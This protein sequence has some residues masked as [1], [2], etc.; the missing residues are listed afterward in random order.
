MKIRFKLFLLFLIVTAIP[1]FFISVIFYYNAEE[2]LEDSILKNLNFVADAKTH[3]IEMTFDDLKTGLENAQN[4]SNVKK[5]LP[6]IAKFFDDKSGRDYIKT[7]EQLDGQLTVLQKAKEFE[8][9]LLVNVSGKIVYDFNPEH[10]KVYLGSFIDDISP[11][12]FE[13]SKDKIYFSDP[14]GHKKEV[15]EHFKDEL[16]L[17]AA[18]P[19]HDFEGKFIGEVVF[20][21]DLKSIFDQFNQNV[22]KTEETVIGKKIN[23]NEIL[24]IN[25]LLFDK[26][27]ALN[28][29][30]SIGDKFAIPI[31]NA[32]NGKNGSGIVIDYRGVEVLADWRYFSRLDWGI[33]SKIDVK[34]AFAPIN[35]L[36]YII[37]LVA[38]VGFFAV[39]LIVFAISKSISDPIEQ[40]RKGAEIIS[41]GNLNYKIG[42]SSKD[43]IGIFSQTFDKM[44]FQL[45]EL[46][47]NLEQ[48]IKGKTN[49]LQKLNR[50]LMTISEANQVAIKA[51]DEKKL[52]KDVCD[53]LIK[54]GGYR[55]AWVGYKEENENKDVRV[56]ASAGYDNGYL[57]KLKA[58]W[59]DTERGNGPTGIA[60]REGKIVA[61]PDLE[62]EVSFRPW[63]KD[64]L[65]R[66]YKG[67]IAIPLFVNDKV[68]GAISIY[69][70]FV[71]VFTSDE[72]KVLQELA[73]DLSYSIES[74]RNRAEKERVESIL[75]E[76]EERF[77]KIF[78][79]GQYGIILTGADSKFIKV[80]PAFS[81][82]TGYTEAELLAKKFSDIT[83][84]ETVKA[85]TESVPK[86]IRGEIPFY[87]TE[88]RYIK[89]NGEEVWVNLNISVIRNTD[90]SFG[91][92]LGM[93]EDISE[94]KKTEE[95]LRQR[96]EDL[97]KF[98]L[99]VENS[100]DHIII[101][102]LDGN[103]VYANRATEKITGYSVN[104]MLGKKPSLWG[105]QMDQ[106]FYKKMWHT[107]KDEKKTFVGEVNNKRK[108][109]Q[110]YFADVYI[111]PILDEN[112]NIKF[113][114]G[115]ERDITEEKKINQTKN[116]FI[117]IASHQLRTPMTGIRWVVERFLKTEKLTRKGKEYLGDIHMS[118]ERLSQLV[119]DLLNFSKIEAGNIHVF[120][121]RFDLKNFIISTLKEWEPLFARKK[122]SH[123]MVDFPD[124]FFVET[125]ESILSNIL[126]CLISNAIEYTPENGKVKMLFIKKGETYVLGIED[127][128]IG[129]PKSEWDKIFTK[130]GRGSNAKLV[131]PDGTGI[132]LYITSQ[133]SILL[134]GK[135]YFES[136]ENVGS[137]FYVELPL[138]PLIEKKAV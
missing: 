77:R 107:I 47:E 69:S 109:G 14:Y 28:K 129:I 85:D 105:K 7:K 39:M 66:D 90:G 61:F 138:K 136:E 75:K 20:E 3:R 10:G 118:M 132:G 74:I 13:N 101:T 52:L 137:T 127:T 41:A 62:K 68:L 63:A 53:V 32:A 114:V 11:G 18:A 80:N 33:V 133:A 73:S 96:T 12:I 97:Q 98:R 1:I 5:D 78:E 117:S 48:K 38:F 4:Y 111:S 112:D 119:N 29:K 49:D 135:A 116:E 16:A 60:I 26:N 88:K 8:T 65:K 108:N 64:A 35:N 44:T 89:K 82:M 130:F 115:V 110:E 113:F 83:H 17:L 46:Y 81:K 9:V 23:D 6:V 87:R 103:I 19:I 134:G 100:Y 34:E 91:Y 123:E 30:I 55:M 67:S 124:E 2:Y 24:I 54:N 56:V 50:A 76:S 122:I 70:S 128:G 72:I 131:K 36:K 21:M 43:E 37:I 45:K 25:P 42:I 126:Q 102:D 125:D 120:V 79:N 93:V 95:F 58:T 40:L 22:G 59:S 15:V 71:N 121:K 86:L 31:Q 99:A 84:P 92:F 104:E 94:R 57:D 106:Q 51:V 27:A